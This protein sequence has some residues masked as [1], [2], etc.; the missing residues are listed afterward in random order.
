MNARL[1]K[2]IIIV[3]VISAVLIIGGVVY[4]SIL[5][6]EANQY[7]KTTGTISAI[8]TEERGENTFVVKWAIV[9]Y[10]TPQGT[11]TNK[12]AGVLP[13]RLEEGAEVEVRFNKNNPDV[14]TA[15]MIDWFP[16]VFLLVLGVLYAIGGSL[17]VILR[18]KAGYYAIVEQTDDPTP[19]EDDDFTLV[20]QLEQLS[21]EETTSTN[22]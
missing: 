16:A 14:V 4:T 13:P 17:V 5:G 6:V 20:D 8:A 2:L 19:I 18:K 22:N 12:L 3:V 9:T 10:E 7:S 11:K 15:E 21:E 1:R